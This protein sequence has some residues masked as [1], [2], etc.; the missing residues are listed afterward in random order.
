MMFLN[1]YQM[2]H[3]SSSDFPE[4]HLVN[5]AMTFRLLKKTGFVKI[6]VIYGGVYKN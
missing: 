4:S 2:S 5:E 1:I 6:Y 3:T